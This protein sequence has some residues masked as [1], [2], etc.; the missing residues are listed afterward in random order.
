MTSQGEPSF[1]KTK[2]DAE[3][4]FTSRLFFRA[5]LISTVGVESLDWKGALYIGVEIKHQRVSCSSHVPVIWIKP[6]THCV[7]SSKCKE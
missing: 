7:I 6:K 4:D 3:F 1:L 5:S 2:R